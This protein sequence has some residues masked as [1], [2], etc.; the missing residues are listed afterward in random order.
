M[1]LTR[2]ESVG[3]GVGVLNIWDEYVDAHSIRQLDLIINQYID[4]RVVAYVRDEGDDLRIKVVNI[5][6]LRI[7]RANKIFTL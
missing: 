6:K 7:L 2:Q 3:L 5:D 1:P 4:D